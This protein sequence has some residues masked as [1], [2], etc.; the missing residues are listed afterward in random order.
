MHRI[1]R[2]W[3]RPAQDAPLVEAAELRLVAGRGVEGDHAFGRMR[4][5]TIVFEDD[6]RAATAELGRDVD[7]SGRRAN[8]LVS[9]GGGQRFVGAT[10]RLGDAV[11]EVKGIVAPCPV[12]DRAAD[13]LQEALKPSG[14]AGIWGR[15]VEGALVRARDELTGPL[16]DPPASSPATAS[17]PG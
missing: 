10:I 14:R 5:V 15:I 17:P 11:V 9:G 8:V 4:H 1:L 16:A 12:M 3:V 6:W 2:L 7:P 13:G